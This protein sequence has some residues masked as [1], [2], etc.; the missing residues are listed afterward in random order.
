MMGRTGFIP[1]LLAMMALAGCQSIFDPSIEDLP[2]S[3]AMPSTSQAGTV[4]VQYYDGIYGL[5]VEDL[6]AADAFP[7]DATEVVP[8]NELARLS[9]R[10]D[11]YGAF[12]RGYIIP[13]SSG[14]YQFFLASDDASTFYL[15][16]DSTT[17]NLTQI[18]HV[19]GWTGIE[20]Y[21]KYSSQR[22]GSIQLTGGTRYYFELL[23]K[24]A[25]GGDHFSVAWS[26][27]GLTQKMI[28]G[29]YLASWAPSIYEEQESG[30]AATNYSLGYRVGYF[31]GDKGLAFSPDYPPLD[32]DE[33]GLY[34]NWEVYYGLDPT[35][36]SDASAD[37]DGDLLTAAEEFQLGT[38]PT[39]PDT[40]GDGLSDGEK[41]AYGLDPLDPDDVYVEID[42]ETVNLYEYLHGEP[43]PPELE[44][45][46]GFVGHYFTGEDFNEFVFTRLDD[47][48]AFSWGSG[49]PDPAIPSDRFSVRWFTQLEPPHDSGTLSYQLN[50]RGDDGV[51]AWL[52]GEQVI[53]GW[54][55][56]APTV[57]SALIELDVEQAPYELIVEYFEAGGGATVELWLADPQTGEVFGQPGIFQRPSLELTE[58]TALVDSDSDGIPD[59][60]ELSY[61]LNPWQDDSTTVYNNQG[62][63]NIETYE[64]GVHPWTLE[65]VSDPVESEAS[66]P[67]TTAPETT[68]DSVTLGW[69]APS[70]RTD[71]SSI[72]LSEIDY[73]LIS[74]GQ[75]A[76][77]LEQEVE[78]Q[79]GTTNHTFE[80]LA[81]GTWYFQVQAVDTSGLTSPSSEVVSSSVP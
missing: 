71:G 5:S 14:S 6:T 11:N 61:G 79:A 33:D 26:G 44:L 1:L 65:E 15:S 20:A 3:A 78:V 54:V 10:G 42:G 50:I 77:T 31:D 39:N 27:P 80:G 57:Y 56:Q 16:S 59:V 9:K 45:V 25:T 36:T 52:N 32:Q 75:D 7:E 30:D 72:A 38:D 73:Y 41:Y 62:L 18:A 4:Y 2:P 19:P 8:L 69:T 55:P 53:D 34:D 13:P 17:D 68:E 43:A 47:A 63:T 64:M 46:S 29:E 74:Y 49:S 67:E 12:V 58:Q 24:Q 60:W 70:T 23:H 51:R 40:S 48:V 35:D 66:A 21:S 22:S 37:T 76:Q 28:T 81:T